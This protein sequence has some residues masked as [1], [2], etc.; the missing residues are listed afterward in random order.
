MY[1]LGSG[2]TPASPAAG[3][4]TT[5]TAGGGGGAGNL[6]PTGVIQIT[7]QDKEAIERVRI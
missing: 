7:P 1:F 6:L 3:A 4:N 2:G 5:A